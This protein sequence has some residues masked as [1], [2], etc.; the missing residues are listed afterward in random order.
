MKDEG[1]KRKD[2][3]KEGREGWKGPGNERKDEGKERKD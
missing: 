2:G 1:K 3:P